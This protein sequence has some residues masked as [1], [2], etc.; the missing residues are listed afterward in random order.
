MDIYTIIPRSPASAECDPVI[1]RETATTRLVFK[2]TLVNNA[3]DHGAPLNGSFV[4]Q[5]KSVGHWEDYNEVPLARLR[6]NEWVKLDLK[7]GEVHTL[8]QHMAGLYRVYRRHGLPR[9][10]IHFFKIDLAA[11]DAEE[12][13]RLDVRRL[14]ELSRRT[15]VDVFSQLIEW[16]VQLGNAAEVLE[17][18]EHLNI[19]TLQRLNS[20]VGITSL[21]TVLQ[22]WEE[23][24]R[25]GN[26]EFWQQTLEQNAFV[27]SQV[28]SFPVFVIRGKAYVGGKAIDN[29]GGHLVDFL[30]ANPF[31]KNAVIVEI[32]TPETRLL[33]RQYRGDVYSAS[34]DLSGAVVQVLNYRYSLTTDFLSV[35]RQY[36]G[37]FDVFS[38]HCLVI[39]GHAKHQLTTDDHRKCFEIIRC[40]CK[41]GV[42]LTYDELFAKTRGLIEALEGTAVP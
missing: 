31:T 42:V 11:S 1:L 38:P 13:A 20:L 35:R 9:K 32:K 2:P 17:R 8:L 29:T 26:E 37:V 14:F 18:L 34:D 39:V 21:K 4:F 28:F 6:A 10:K 3:H 7:A 12:I 5:R 41:D 19:N 33:G 22:Q 40:G 15:G 36:E 30:A 23:N 25:N 16:A 27:L 24:Q